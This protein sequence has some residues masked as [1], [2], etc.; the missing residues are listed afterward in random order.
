MLIRRLLLS[1]PIALAALA[2]AGPALAVGGNYAVDGATTR[3]RAQVRSALAVSAFDWGVVRAR[4][5]I[6]VRRGTVT[7]SAPGEIWVDADLLDAGRYSWAFVQH[8]YG[9]QV[10]FFT[11]DD[12]ARARL[13]ESLR[14]KE[15][16]WGT[17]GLAHADH[18]CERFASTLAWAYWP[19]KNNALR[20]LGPRDE[21]G[22]M[23]PARFRALLTKLLGG[24][25]QAQF[26]H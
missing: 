15:W 6:H 26:W 17:P 21:S 24:P 5:R 20:P 2:L 9:H 23:Q 11:F 14:G 4:V 3:E 22:A 13:N 16:W 10:D 18:G 19:S 1:L 12:S 7:R 8:E 25:R